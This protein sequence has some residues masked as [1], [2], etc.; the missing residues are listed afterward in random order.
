MLR[1]FVQSIPS[2]FKYQRNLASGSRSPNTRSIALPPP[3][4]RGS[5]A[6]QRY[7]P[8]SCPV[9]E[10]GARS[11]T[12]LSDERVSATA[13]HGYHVITRGGCRVQWYRR[14]PIAIW[15]LLLLLLRWYLQRTI[16][17]RR[18]RRMLAFPVPTQIDLP[19][20]RFLAETALKRFVAGV[21]THVRDQVA[22]LGERLAAHDTFVRFFTCNTE[23]SAW[24]SYVV[25]LWSIIIMGSIQRYFNI[26]WRNLRHISKYV[27]Q[28]WK[29]KSPIL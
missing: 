15:L 21:F 8:L 6:I 20:E 17:E 19:L 3:T 25:A 16:I 27:D 18:C 28:K 4:S 1:Y 7:L 23:S 2:E 24:V 22:A 26:V 29:K 10:P 9:W 13:G 5:V 14:V 11:W 12:K